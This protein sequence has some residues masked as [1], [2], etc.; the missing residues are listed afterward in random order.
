[1][2]AWLTRVQEGGWSLSHLLILLAL[3]SLWAV[4]NF[5]IQAAA[6]ATPQP[7]QTRAYESVRLALNFLAAMA[8]LLACTWRVLVVLL[9][10][11]FLLALGLVAYTQYFHRA[12]SLYYSLRA[13]REGLQAR[14]F[15]FELIPLRA[16]AL[17]SGILAA[18]LLLA[19]RLAS[20]SFEL[21]Y[22]AA[23][24]CLLLAAGIVL[25]LQ[26]TTINFHNLATARASRAV[27]AYGYLI[28]WVAEYLVTP[29]TRV[30]E[31]LIALQKQSPDR[32][33]AA[34]RPWQFGDM[35]VVVQVE[36]WGWN[37]LNYSVN[38]QEVMPYLNRLSRRGRL[39][40]TQAFHE[41][42]SVD[43]DFAVLSGGSP[44]RR[45][46]SYLVP[47]ISYTNAL[48]RFL[49]RHQFHT[50]AIHGGSGDFFD[51]RRGFS[52]MGFDEIWFKEDLVKLNLRQSSWGI[53]DAAVFEFSSQ[54]LRRAAGPEFHF[55]IT[56]DSHGPFDLIDDEEK[57]V[58]PHSEVWQENYF[59]SM[60]V[61]D[62]DLR[63][64]LESLP[65]GTLVILYGDH[66]SGVNYGDFRSAREGE[67]EYVHCLVH[68][69]GSPEAP[70][71]Q[72]PEVVALP[73]DLRILDVMN[74][75]RHQ[76]ATR[77]PALGSAVETGNTA[78]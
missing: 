8:L 58:F 6:F 16:W 23:M 53:R 55:I 22:P 44:S 75:L 31:E 73:E 19:H 48:P 67:A 36:S 11:D 5:F 57:E 17:L 15:A 72:S 28:S 51:R 38:G 59:N 54:R 13:L 71:I 70:P 64:Y 43:M 24:L 60:H 40:R 63:D 41:V 1:M 76:I 49:R 14:S 33:A 32:L 20:R 65:T 9:V 18:K 29:S 46:V 77:A 66:T 4:E 62:R 7:G 12:F 30:T 52:E 21:G 35:V 2:N 78:R 27:Y 56:L 45:V 39:F 68:V 42:G 74:C 3:A 69:C 61:L 10:G 26:C 25:G 50:V 47:G 37:V 34:E